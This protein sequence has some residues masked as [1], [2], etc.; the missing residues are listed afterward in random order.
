MGHWQKRLSLVEQAF[1]YYLK[2]YQDINSNK[3]TSFL[4]IGGGVG[5]YARAA[6]NRGI[7][8]C[9]ADSA[10]DAL[11]FARDQLKVSWIVKCNIQKCADFLESDAFD[12]VLSRHT[13]EHMVDPEEFIYN[14]AQLL[15]RGGILEIETPNV[16]SNEQFCHPMVSVETYRIIREHNP[17]LSNFSAFKYA[18]FK[19]MSGVNPPKHLWGFTKKRA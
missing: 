9:L 17:S 11:E 10:D 13:V 6:M 12:F 18:F 2:S 3:P 8:A 15:K 16:A 4:D 7:D 19:S 14:I 1:D 5:Y